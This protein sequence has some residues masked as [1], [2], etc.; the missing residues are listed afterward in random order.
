MRTTINVSDNVIAEILKLVKAKTKTEAINRALSDYVRMKR[1]EK[2]RA[3][4][5]KLNID[6]D[7]EKLRGLELNE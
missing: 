7:V 3:L 6:L 2:L 5:G 1:L 4:R